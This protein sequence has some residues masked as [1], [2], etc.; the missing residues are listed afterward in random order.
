MF[1]AGNSRLV[2]EKRII[3]LLRRLELVTLILSN[4]GNA[5][6]LAKVGENLIVCSIRLSRKLSVLLFC[7]SVKLCPHIASSQTYCEL[8][9]SDAASVYCFSCWHVSQDDNAQRSIPEIHYCEIL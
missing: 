6:P 5:Y 4:V 1:Q 2:L 7:P 8:T 9:L 3:F